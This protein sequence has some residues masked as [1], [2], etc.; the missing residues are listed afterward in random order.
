MGGHVSDRES[1]DPFEQGLVSLARS[2]YEEAVAN[3][4]E[5][6]EDSD[7]ES[8]S[9]RWFLT[10]AKLGETYF[11]LDKR[12][13]ADAH[14]NI[15]ANGGIVDSLVLLA[16]IAERDGDIYLATARR[17]LAASRGDRDS[18]VWVETRS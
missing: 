14:L 1:V 12:E 13:L 2:R 10:H 16:I 11:R 7:S 6:L 17:A 3:F 4:R 8:D 5:A 9:D 15:A 18:Q